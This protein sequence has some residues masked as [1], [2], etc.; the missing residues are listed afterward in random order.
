MTCSIPNSAG[1][2]VLVL[3]VAALL[4]V[5]ACG[6]LS[7]SPQVSSE[8]NSTVVKEA[9]STHLPKRGKVRLTAPPSVAVFGM[10]YINTTNNREFI[11]DGSQ[12]VP[13]DRSIDT[14]YTTK[15]SAKSTALI[16]S[17]VCADG[18]PS[19]TPTGAHGGPAT[20]LP[21]H[22]AYDCKVCH[23]IGGR[24]SFD[25]YGPA[26]S[27]GKPAPAFNATTKTCS[28]IAC[29]GIPSGTFSYYFQGGDGEPVLNT[30]SYGGSTMVVTP[31]WYSTG[32]SACATCHGNPPVNGSN[33]SNVWHSGYHG[34][35]G[36][37]ATQNQCQF[38]HPDASSPGNGAGDTIT[39]PL[40]HANGIV[41]VQATFKSSC[42]GCH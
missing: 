28:N 20:V 38:C 22:S 10:I 19:C 24:L 5:S 17:D 32:S 18:D 40:L 27:V 25:K 29:H 42:F 8:S 15:S 35:G 6:E 13:H 34:N 7:Q 39:N 33:G 36:P 26:Y 12:W 14:F 21:G 23:K 2:N 1:R 31:S 3:S 16:Q 41:N 4:F 37:T 30:V 9:N 11:F